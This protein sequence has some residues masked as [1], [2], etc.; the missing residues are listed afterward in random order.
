M[1]DC[2]IIVKNTNDAIRVFH[3]MNKHFGKKIIKV[4]EISNTLHYHRSAIG[5]ILNHRRINLSI[6]TLQSLFGLIGYE[7][8]FIINKKES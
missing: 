4:K 7:I 3:S 6:E 2:K 1:S 5:D 8:K